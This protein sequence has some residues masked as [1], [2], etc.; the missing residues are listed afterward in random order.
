MSPSPDREGSDDPNTL[1]WSSQCW[2]ISCIASLG[3]LLVNGH[4]CRRIVGQWKRHGSLQCRQIL[5]FVVWG[6][7]FSGAKRN[8][9]DQHI[10]GPQ[11]LPWCH[12]FCG[13]T[14]TALCLADACT[15]WAYE[16]E[17]VSIGLLVMIV[18]C[19]KRC[20]ED[21]RSWS[22]TFYRCF[23]ILHNVSIFLCKGWSNS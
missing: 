2:V 12:G 15:S 22:F 19:S 9:S 7:P 11:Q 8:P 18:W 3:F 17:T 6:E 21:E 5:S 20:C 23:M 13:S 14:P 16:L 4:T 10:P 1:Q